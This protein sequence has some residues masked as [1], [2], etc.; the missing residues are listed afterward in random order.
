[1]E[2][3]NPLVSGTD[4]EKANIVQNLNIEMEFVLENGCIP[5]KEI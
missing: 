4:L 2:H 1:M 5:T 3:I